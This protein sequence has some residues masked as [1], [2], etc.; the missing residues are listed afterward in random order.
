MWFY[1]NTDLKWPEI[2]SIVDGKMFDSITPFWKFRRLSV[3][4]ALSSNEN[5]IFNVGQGN[6]ENKMD[7]QFAGFQGNND[8]NAALN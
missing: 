2:F 3:E 4:E 6:W 8:Q 1:S 7:L 5:S